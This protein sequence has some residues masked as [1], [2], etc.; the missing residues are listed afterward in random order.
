MLI[1]NLLHEL[2]FRST[3]NFIN[4][5]QIAKRRGSRDIS[6][7]DVPSDKIV[8]FVEYYPTQKWGMKYTSKVIILQ[9]EV[10]TFS[11]HLT[12][13]NEL[14]ETFLTIDNGNLSEY[15]YSQFSKERVD[16]ELY[17]FIK[18]RQK[19]VVSCSINISN[20]LQVMT[21]L[22]MINDF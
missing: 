2:G 11:E 3:F 8:N 10:I 5:N 19:S 1:I 20:L 18:T 12:D 14:L 22:N 4:Y 7:N 15:L 13:S 6:I 9:T 21:S 16:E 17:K